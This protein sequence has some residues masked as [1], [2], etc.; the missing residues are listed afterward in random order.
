MKCSTEV[1]QTFLD[2]EMEPVE[3]EVVRRHLGCC[4][5]CRQ[6]LSRLRLLWLE[7]GQGEEIEVPE[8][9]PFI[10]QQAVT[11]ARAAGQEV[12]GTS[13]VSLWE[14]Q[15][16]AWQPVL[17]GIVQIPGSRQ[18]GRL[19]MLTG[20]GLPTVIRGLSSLAGMITGRKR[21]RR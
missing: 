10:R 13:G 16:L 17:A 6:E 1:L 3:I 11:R 15:K 2:G 4:P 5:F 7:L 21:G 9:L 12:E 20:R 18:I 19:A 8:I 14:A